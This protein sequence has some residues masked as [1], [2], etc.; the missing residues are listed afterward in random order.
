MATPLV[1]TIIC[2]TLIGRGPQ[3]SALHGCV[4]EATTGH[5]QT[6]LLAGEA[7]IGKSRLAAEVGDYAATCGFHIVA[8]HC[9]EQDEALPYAPFYEVLDAL[10]RAA[11]R[12]MQVETVRMVA[13][14]LT[15]VVP[16]LAALFPDLPLNQEVAHDPEQEKRR[17]V[18]AFV[19]LVREIA[20]RQP[21]FI[22]IED[23]HW[24]D[25]ASLD[26]L[27]YLAQSGHCDVSA[28]LLRDVGH[29]IGG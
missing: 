16:E 6:V 17:F 21:L 12:R 2:P 1:K 18:R 19:R 7:G 9:C 14:D 23:M 24:C 25:E 11:P 4:R 15:R 13:P 8:G 27:L 20:A 26:A 29:A 10:L 28:G 3:L 22:L 5:G